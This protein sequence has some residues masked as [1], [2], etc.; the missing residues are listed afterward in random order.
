M[1][2]SCSDVF[3]NEGGDWVGDLVDD[4]GVNGNIC[5][6]PLFCDAADGDLSIRDDSPCAPGQD[7]GCGIIG[8]L[9]VGCHV[10]GADDWADADGVLSIGPCVPN[11][12]RGSTVI[13][14]YVPGNA[15]TGSAGSAGSVQLEIYD[16]AG[17]RVRE[18]VRSVSEPGPHDTEW[19]GRDDADQPVHA[20]TYFCRIWN[21]AQ[22]RTTRVVVIR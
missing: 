1:T 6:D 12:F 16:V 22:T 4:L 21:A 17:R 11:P 10:A 5:A 2:I 9:P 14:F 18:L 3:G 15:Q 19:D 13:R 20:G 8:A 7:P